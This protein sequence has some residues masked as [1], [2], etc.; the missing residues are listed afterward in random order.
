MGESEQVEEANGG[1]EESDEVQS[2]DSAKLPTPEP[3]TLKVDAKCLKKLVDEAVH[4]TAA[5]P[6]GALERLGARLSAAIDAYKHRWDRT[7]LSLQLT[8]ILH[9]A[10]LE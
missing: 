4:K 9:E 8:T 10:A 3:Q 6:V 1:E 5:W 2:H 7:A